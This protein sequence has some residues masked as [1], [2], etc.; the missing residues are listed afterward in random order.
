MTGFAYAR[1]Q[2][3]L[4]RETVRIAERMM[5][6]S[7]SY[8]IEFEAILLTAHVNLLAFLLELRATVPRRVASGSLPML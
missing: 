5:L 7:M 3:G 4:S 8:E 1:G 6:L 2:A